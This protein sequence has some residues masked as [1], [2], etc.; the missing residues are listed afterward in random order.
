VFTVAG[1]D[2]I[3]YLKQLNAAASDKPFFL[4]YVPGGTR[5]CGQSRQLGCSSSVY[6]AL[7]FWRESRSYASAHRE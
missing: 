5:D 3:Q 2:R 7:L 6:F 4:Y 1:G